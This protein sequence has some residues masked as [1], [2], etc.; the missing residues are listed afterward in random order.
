MKITE[1]IIAYGHEN[2]LATHKS[3]FEITKEMELSR[4]G[5]CIIAVSANKSLKNLSLEFKRHLLRENA[6]I[7]VLIEA[8]GIIET[9]KA[10]GSSKLILT[11]PTDIVIRKSDYICARTLAIKADKAACDLSRRLVDK[12]KNPR[13]KVKITLTMEI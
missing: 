5:N 8:E 10:Y 1:D 12:L 2:I 11:H 9:V 3:T 13:Q 6:K 4:R 7:T